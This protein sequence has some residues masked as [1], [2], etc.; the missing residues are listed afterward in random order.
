MLQEEEA[1]LAEQKR[2]TAELKMQKE[3]ERLEREALE[4]QLDYVKQKEAA[5][6]KEFRD[7]LSSED[8]DKNLNEE[9]LG[10]LTDRQIQ[11][12]TIKKE[13]LQEKLRKVTNA[14]KY[15]QATGVKVD[16]DTLQRYE[17]IRRKVA[18]QLRICIK[19]LQAQKQELQKEVYLLHLK[20]LSKRLRKY[21]LILQY[22]GNVYHL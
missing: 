17:K 2:I 1:R 16:A 20:L 4:K 18:K 15:V 19:F 3:K 11:G 21:L 13:Y 22:K 12:A 9:N 7:R 14:F 5:I 6:H 8:S 10:K